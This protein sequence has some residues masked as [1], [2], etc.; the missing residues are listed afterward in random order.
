MPTFTSQAPSADNWMDSGAATTNNGSS[1][2]L[3]VGEQN[4]ATRTHRALIKY[5]LS[6]IPASAN[7]TSATLTLTVAANNSVNAR[8]IHM[9]RVL[10]AWVGS[11]STWNIYSTGNNWGTAGCSNTTSDR[12][13]A[14]AGS[15][16]Q[17]S[18]PS[19]GTQVVITLDN[20]KL[21]EMIAGSFA[22]NGWLLQVET[23][24]NDQVNYDSVES[25]TA[26]ERPLLTINYTLLTGT[27]TVTGAMT[28]SMTVSEYP[29][30]SAT[31]PRNTWTITAPD[32]GEG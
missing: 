26:E 28:A 9:Y 25:S 15:G 29:V 13:S 20:D 31:V 1:N 12:E 6:S 22:N 14:S 3:A 30:W 2:V 17:P 16:T 11:E 7:V 8:T 27:S 24:T 5:D 21:K 18:G 10:R 4:G 19:A 32:I 23:E